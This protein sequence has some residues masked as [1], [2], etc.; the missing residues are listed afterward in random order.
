MHCDEQVPNQCLMAIDYQVMLQQVAG[1]V[2]R[3]HWNYRQQRSGLIH[4]A[5]FMPADVDLADLGWK[6]HLS[7]SASE[8]LKLIPVITHFL[9]ETQSPFKMPSNY[10]SLLLL[11]DG[12][13]GQSQ[14]GKIITVYTLGDS[15]LKRLAQNI[16]SFWRSTKGPYLVS[17]LRV[18]RNPRIGLRFGVMA[19]AIVRQDAVGRHRL[20]MNYNGCLYE[21]VRSLTANQ[22]PIATRLP[23]NDIRQASRLEPSSRVWQSLAKAQVLATI[24][25]TPSRFV[26][27][28]IRTEPPFNT[29]V[30]KVARTGVGECRLRVSSHPP[31]SGSP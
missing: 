28:C 6:F 11:N 27:L 16:S 17:D 5:S 19:R 22:S 12:K 13:G 20:M 2:Q 30:V 26:C 15:H 7:C 23:F 21:D 1:L 8:S 25:N 4:W 10:E 14:V 24:Q 9:L 3:R 29:V 31:V 18:N